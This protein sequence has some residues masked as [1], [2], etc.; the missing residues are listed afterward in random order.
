MKKYEFDFIHV[1]LGS[2]D[3]KAQIGEASLEGWEI[4][5]VVCSED[6]RT[7]FLQR[8]INSTSDEKS[9]G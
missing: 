1:R 4:K 8:E 5:S 2:F 3:D 9:N 7:Y 6:Y